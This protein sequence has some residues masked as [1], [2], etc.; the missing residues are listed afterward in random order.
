MNI[1]YI[2][3]ACTLLTIPSTTILPLDFLNDPF[4]QQLASELDAMF[5]EEPVHEKTAPNPAPSP[6]FPPLKSSKAPET[7]AEGTKKLE[8]PKKDIHDSAKDLKTLFIE[9]LV[10]AK[11]ANTSKNT[12]KAAK[13]VITKERMKAYHHYMDNLVKKGRF[14]ERCVASN[15]GRTFGHHFLATFNEAI[16][17]IDQIETMHHLII[18]KKVYLRKFFGPNLQKTREQ[19]VKVIGDL[20]TLLRKLRLIITKEEEQDDDIARM[21]KEASITS[22]EKAT[23]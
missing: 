21:H 13:V 5:S 1:K 14:V 4:F 20:D 18:S 16:S 9:D 3:L 8:E 2:A 19:I 12:K 23:Q 11:D 17:F 7:V 10:A 15:P 22:N 6:A